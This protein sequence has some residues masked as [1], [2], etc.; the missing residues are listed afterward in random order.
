[1]DR[2]AQADLPALDV[3]G[4]NAGQALRTLAEAAGL[5]MILEGEVVWLRDK[6]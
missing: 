2:L 5:R 1:M 3:R 6:P 4:K